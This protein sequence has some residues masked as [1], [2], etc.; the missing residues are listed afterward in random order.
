M[1][2]KDPMI[3]LS[4]AEQALAEAGDIIDILDLRT[5]AKAIE[6]IAVAEHLGDIAQQ[7]K[8]FQIKAERKAGEWLMANIRPGRPTEDD[9]VKLT[10]LDIT[11]NDSSR[12]QLIARLDEAKFQGWLD[13]RLSKGQ[14]VTAG[15]L[16]A[17]AKNSL[18]LGGG[19]G[20]TSTARLLLDPVNTC[21]LQGYAIRCD[22]PPQRGHIIH[23]GD[24][25]GNDKARAILAAIPDEI[26]AWQCS[27][28]NVGRF[29]NTSEAKRIQLLQKIYQYG[30]LHMYDW[31]EYFHSCFK[32]SPRPDLRLEYLLERKDS[33]LG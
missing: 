8:V 5:K 33:K 11:Y 23:K 20:S 27:S 17:Y 32:K 6:T 4:K 2:Q 7:A 13:E 30:W 19:G 3:R 25:Q 28:H 15:G 10:D 12:W 21:A 18:G 14:E 29:A 1:T 26:M 9:T 16:H 31:F 22:G 24:V